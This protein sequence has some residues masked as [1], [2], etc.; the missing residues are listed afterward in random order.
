MP[1]LS[2]HFKGIFYFSDNRNQGRTQ[3]RGSPSQYIKGS[4]SNDITSLKELSKNGC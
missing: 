2:K 1:L 3:E 4:E